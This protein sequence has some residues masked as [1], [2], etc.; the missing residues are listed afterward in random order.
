[1]KFTICQK[2]VGDEIGIYVSSR[3]HS[4][5]IDLRRECTVEVPRRQVGARSIEVRERTARAE[6]KTMPYT[7]RVEIFA[8]NCPKIIETRG[9]GAVVSIGRIRTGSVEIGETTTGAAEEARDTRCY[10]PSKTR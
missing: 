10:Y 5:E 3:D 9:L 6:Q 7:G 2:A 1:M 4:K 8:R